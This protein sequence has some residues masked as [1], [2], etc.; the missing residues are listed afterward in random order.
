[1]AK[2]QIALTPV[3][4]FFFGGDMTF[5]AEGRDDLNEDFQSYIIQ[6]GL[7][8]QQT[9]L[10]GMLRF[11]ILRND[12]SCFRD[13]QITDKMKAAD[14]IGP[15]SFSVN[16]MTDGSGRVNS[17]GVIQSISRCRLQVI[18]AG[19]VSSL[20][21][22]PMYRKDVSWSEQVAYLNDHSVHMPV[23]DYSPKE[24]LNIVLSDGKR[25]YGFD[26]IYVEDRRIGINRTLSTGK[27]DDGALFKQ[28]SYRFKDTDDRSFRFSF[29]ADVDKVDIE[30]Y[31]G[32]LVSVGGDSSWFVLD[33]SKWTEPTDGAYIRD[34][35]MIT[36]LSPAY[37]P[38]NALLQTRFGITSLVSFR[39]LKTSVAQ[40]GGYSILNKGMLRSDKYKLYAA[41]SQFFFEDANQKA[42]FISLLESRKDFCQI[43]Y[44]E[45]Q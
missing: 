37:I 25:D 39:F 26:D 3:D 9:S 44:N 2:Y 5:K 17:F 42:E 35:L 32:Q 38:R 18:T 29:V 45:Y 28:I 40:E 16:S 34:D 31:S 19:G 20:D 14:L 27:I 1:M 15:R 11:L 13:G 10:L 36:L 30:S 23:L 41:G 4:K 8:P 12:P 33:I 24:G 21:V 43:G 7:F 6:S 22:K